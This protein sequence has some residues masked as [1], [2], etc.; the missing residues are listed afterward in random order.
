MNLRGPLFFA[1]G[2]GGVR[3]GIPSVHDRKAHTVIRAALAAS[4]AVCLFVGLVHAAPIDPRLKAEA[5]QVTITRD[6][7]GIAHVQAPTDALAVFGGVYAQAEDD[8]N[9]VE[10]NYIT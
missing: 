7:W 5:A 1:R 2:R 10:T 6:D 8:F 4:A 9:R 3:H